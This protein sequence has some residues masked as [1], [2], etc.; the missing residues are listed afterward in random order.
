MIHRL[1]L[2]SHR[3]GH[4]F[5][6]ID[7]DGYI[8]F[9]RYPYWGTSLCVNADNWFEKTSVVRVK[10]LLNLNIKMEVAIYTQ[11]GYIIIYDITNN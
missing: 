10:M 4:P 11:N 9:V 3:I 7:G 5:I 2:A 6:T 1:P 8:D